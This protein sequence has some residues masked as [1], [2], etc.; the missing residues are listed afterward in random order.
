M[1]YLLLAA[2]LLSETPEPAVPVQT[3]PLIP[4]SDQ[5]LEWCRYVDSFPAGN[6]RIYVRQITIEKKCYTLTYEDRG[7]RGKNV[8]DVL[9]IQE[10]DTMFVDEGADGQVE[11]GEVD[12][13]FFLKDRPPG[14]IKRGQEA[15]VAL[16]EQ[17][18]KKGSREGSLDGQ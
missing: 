14:L 18:A 2:A 10:R 1:N 9:T 4:V 7:K 15:Y 16:L 6:G 5:V 11:S 12:G 8:E 17:I 3:P 13:I